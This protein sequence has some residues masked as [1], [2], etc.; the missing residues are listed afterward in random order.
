VK[1]A[2]DGRYLLRWGAK[3]AGPGQLDLPHALTIDDAGRVLVVDRGN[4]RVQIFDALGGYRST[5][6]G[7]PF[8]S[9]QDIDLARDGTAFVVDN[10]GREPGK[11]AVVVLRPDGVVAGRIGRRGNADG[12]FVDPHW[13]AVARSGAVY[14]ADFGGRRVQKFVPNTAQAARSR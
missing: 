7:P 1:F 8:V 5:W 10:G 12:Q 9:P 2:P 6:P 11:M 4:R 14:V 3:G 13:V